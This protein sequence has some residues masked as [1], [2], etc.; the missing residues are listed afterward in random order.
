MTL[1]RPTQPA[2][3]PRRSALTLRLL[4]AALVTAGLLTAQ[5]APVCS[6]YVLADNDTLRFLGTDGLPIATHATTNQAW[7]LQ[8]DLGARIVAVQTSGVLMFD[9]IGNPLGGLIANLGS[10]Q[11]IRLGD[12]RVVVTDDNGTKIFDSNGSQVGVT[13]GKTGTQRQE[14]VVD[15]GLVAVIDEFEIR[16]FDRD[17]SRVG[18]SVNRTGNSRQGVKFTKDRIIVI[19]DDRVRIYD[20]NFSLVGVSILRSGTARPTVTVD[21][22]RIIV[23][24]TDGVRIFDAGRNQQGLP[25]PKTGTRTQRV[26]TCGNRILVIDTDGVR[27]FDRNGSAVG[28]TISTSGSFHPDVQTTPDRIIVTDD[29]GTRVYDKNRNLLRTINT[30]GTQRHQIVID[31]DRIIL[32]AENETRILDRNGNQVGAS[33]P[34]SG[35][36]TQRVRIEGDRILVI[37]DGQIRIYDR[38]GTQIGNAVPVSGVEEYDVELWASVITVV[39]N[40]STV[41]ILNRDGSQRGSTISVTT[42]VR[43]I[44]SAGDSLLIVDDN[45]TRVFDMFA[46]QRGNSIIGNGDPESHVICF[47]P[48]VLEQFGTGCGSAFTQAFGEPRLGGEIEVEHFGQAYAMTAF[49]IGFGPTPAPVDLSAIGATGCTLYTNVDATLP[50]PANFEGRAS[51]TLSLGINRGLL[52]LELRVQVLAVDPGANALGVTTSNATRIVLGDGI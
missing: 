28:I 47:T 46:N 39:E 40:F 44:K 22:D 45:R 35:Q 14:V 31:G 13:I 1:P 10:F 49:A 3:A 50:T 36:N 16:I 7:V 18:V 17:G 5:Q 42:G 51:Q 4:G 12:D 52:G 32:V 37:D 19:D 23:I 27:V 48:G 25:I 24:D 43:H 6:A 9:S 2:N 15:C 34:R 41:R 21:G 33:V 11:S 30:T 8:T 20:K 26:Q 29:G 38:N